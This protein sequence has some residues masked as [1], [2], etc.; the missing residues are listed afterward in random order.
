M[1]LGWLS[2]AAQEQSEEERSLCNA[3]A[4]HLKARVKPRQGLGLVTGV[5][6]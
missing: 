6:V 4:E 1:N 5:E 3:V 2:P